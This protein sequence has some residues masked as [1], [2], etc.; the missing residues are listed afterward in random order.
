MDIRKKLFGRN[1]PW[2][3]SGTKAVKY[4]PVEFAQLMEQKGAGEIIV[5]SIDR[6]GSMEGS[7]IDLLK[8]ISEAVS[9]PVVALG[10]AGRISDLEE[11]YKNAKVN[12]L[13]A[14]SLFVYKNK[15][16]G[17][18]INYPE[19]KEMSNLTTL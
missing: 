10:G 9:I 4:D 7:D 18:L 3:F 1:C 19:K 14:G 16:R 12:A 11:A 6:D 13:A 5:Q 8:A 2:I 17:V 15:D